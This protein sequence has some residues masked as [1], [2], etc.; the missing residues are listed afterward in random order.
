MPALGLS[1]SK[2]D[3]IPAAGDRTHADMQAFRDVGCRLNLS[4]NVAI[5]KSP[6]GD[7]EFC[8]KYAAEKVR[9]A[10]EGIRAIADLPDRHCGLHLLRYQIGKL[11]Y[12]V[13]TTP[14]ECIQQPLAA[15]D[16][17]VRLAYER[18]EGK[19][20]SDEAWRQMSL[21]TRHAGGGFRSVAFS[22]DAAYYASRVATHEQCKAVYPQ[23]ANGHMDEVDQQDT[24]HQTAQRISAKIPATAQVVLPDQEGDPPRQQTV[25]RHMYQHEFENMK[26]SAEP[27][28]RARLNAYCGLAWCEPTIAEI[29]STALELGDFGPHAASLLMKV[30]YVSRMVR[31]VFFMPLTH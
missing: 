19:P 7:A 11:N 4:R 24:L 3:V 31:L 30:V 25:L 27:L 8:T 21:P 22:A 13:R 16:V 5:M 9:E 6:I 10:T 20:V 2:L 1:F 14:A 12:L 17:Q 23:F 26:A 29:N 28:V 15:F 18:L